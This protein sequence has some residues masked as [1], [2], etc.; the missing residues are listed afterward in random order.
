VRRQEEDA[1]AGR[2]RLSGAVGAFELDPLQHLLGRQAA[3]LEEFEEHRA[4]VLEDAPA[5]DAAL[6]GGTRR[7]GAHQVLLR[8]AAVGQVERVEQQAE[9]AA[10][11]VRA[12]P[13][14]ATD[15]PGRRGD[16]RVLEPMAKQ[17]VLRTHDNRSSLS[18]SHARNSCAGSITTRIGT[19]ATGSAKGASGS[20]RTRSFSVVRTITAL[21]SAAVAVRR[22]RSAAVKRW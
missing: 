2:R 18:F 4:E 1:A 10:G 3:E 5:D 11:V 13:G 9:Q 20:I 14:Q 17:G 22:P 21:A 19:A 12:A 16:E 6:L 7:E 8:D 15:Q